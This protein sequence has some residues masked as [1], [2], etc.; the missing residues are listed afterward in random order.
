MLTGALEHVHEQLL[1]IIFNISFTSSSYGFIKVV[2][3]F[4]KVIMNINLKADLCLKL[5]RFHFFLN[6]YPRP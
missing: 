6:S 1:G 4:I 3:N 5:P 2:M